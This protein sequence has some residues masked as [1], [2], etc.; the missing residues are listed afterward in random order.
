MEISFENTPLRDENGKI[1]LDASG[2]PILY[3]YFLNDMNDEDE[4]DKEQIALIKREAE[5]EKNL[6]KQ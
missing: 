3:K 1:I 2:N 6:V 4:D 5:Q